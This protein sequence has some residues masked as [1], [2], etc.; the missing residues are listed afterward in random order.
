MD[1]KT[2]GR[3][4]MFSFTKFTL[5]RQFIVVSFLVL[6]GQMVIVGIWI[7]RQIEVG[8]TNRTAAIKSL[9]IESFISPH[10]QNLSRTHH[11]SSEQVA[12][13][14]RVLVETLLEHRIV[15]FKVWGPDGH[16]LFSPNAD[17]IGQQ[18]VM[19]DKLKQAFAGEVLSEISNLREVGDEYE[20][21]GW[22]KLIET[23]VPIRMEGGAE[24]IAVSQ[25]YQ[26]P[27]DLLAE[28][29]AAQLRS[30]LVVGLTTLAI[31]LLLVGLVGRASNIILAQQADLQ[32]N[33]SQL[34]QL[35]TQNKQLHDQVQQAAGRTTALN[36][37][38]L[39]RISADLHDG[40][41]Q[42]LALALLRMESLVESHKDCPNVSMDF[43]TVQ[44]ALESALTELRA[45]SAG[46]RLPEIC[47]LSPAKIIHRAVRD[48]E[49][50]TE[51]LVTL[52]VG[53]LPNDLPLPIKITLYRILQESLTN[54]YRHAGGVGQTVRLEKRLDRLCLEV[55]DAGQGFD[56][57]AVP[58][59]GH[60]GLA[61]MSERVKVLGGRFEVESLTGQGTTI[62]AYLPLIIPEI[63]YV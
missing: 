34:R 16:I 26:T 28:I 44:T 61:G 22:D 46:L 21:Q 59:N 56:P 37:K 58:S 51:R 8:V 45:I 36:E 39:S 42:D 52:T 63:D 48:Y 9:Y 27:D 20:N 10:L 62:R 57:K 5:A 12:A 47:P 41:G 24:V 18:F 14:N 2:T 54:G 1:I 6:L 30:W 40:P 25:F 11:L 7:G 15:S 4:K 49:R 29:R 31:Y 35:L 38:F 13:L 55:A 32:E 60:L 50:K 3:N 33:V 43:F 53:D 23:C 17:L 19:P